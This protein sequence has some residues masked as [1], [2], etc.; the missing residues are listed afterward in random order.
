MRTIGDVLDSTT[1]LPRIPQGYVTKAEKDNAR[2]RIN[3]LLLSLPDR[4]LDALNEALEGGRLA[5]TYGSIFRFKS[6]SNGKNVKAKQVGFKAAYRTLLKR[7]LGN[8][9][10][11]ERLVT[12]IQAYKS[13]TGRTLPN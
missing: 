7:R 5:Q 11:N 4:W 1:L 9:N 12:I 3:A 8:L 6:K 13:L 2:S 10:Y